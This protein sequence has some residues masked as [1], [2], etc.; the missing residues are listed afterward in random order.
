MKLSKKT[1]TI[2]GN[3]V[4]IE[5]PTIILIVTDVR[6]TYPKEPIREVA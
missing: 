5:I 2:T 3:V 6:N 4:P 1:S